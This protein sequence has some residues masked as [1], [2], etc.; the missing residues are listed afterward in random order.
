MFAQTVV[1]AIKLD[2]PFVEDKFAILANK[3]FQAFIFTKSNFFAKSVFRHWFLQV[4]DS[5]V[6]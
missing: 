2:S 6:L 1:K 3:I 5:G 4:L